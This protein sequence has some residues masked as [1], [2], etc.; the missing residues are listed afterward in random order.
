MCDLGITAGLSEAFVEN[1][2]GLQYPDP[3]HLA[4]VSA[5]AS[6]SVGK[7]ASLEAG[8]A[9]RLVILRFASVRAI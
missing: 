3:R 2:Q 9:L 5:V 4:I 7:R 1:T 6:T 8:Q